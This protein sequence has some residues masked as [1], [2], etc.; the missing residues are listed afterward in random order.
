MGLY[1][2]SDARTIFVLYRNFCVL[3]INLPN[4]I[5]NPGKVSKLKDKND[6]WRFYGKHDN[7]RRPSETN[8]LNQS[9][10]QTAESKQNEFVE[11]PSTGRT[12]GSNAVDATEGEDASNVVE[13]VDK[14]CSEEEINTS[15]PTVAAP[16]APVDET[17]LH[18][19]LNK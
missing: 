13:I 4:Y 12:D 11:E 2:I 14:A 16:A 1:V 8:N 9:S 10:N 19:W 17:E 18:A 7:K 15:T 5:I 3:F 6:D